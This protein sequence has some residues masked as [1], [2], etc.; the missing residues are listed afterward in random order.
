[1]DKNGTTFT[2][3]APGFPAN[4]NI[5]EIQLRYVDRTKKVTYDR[6]TGRIEINKEF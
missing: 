5:L 6:R 1:M 3:A 2:G 4:A